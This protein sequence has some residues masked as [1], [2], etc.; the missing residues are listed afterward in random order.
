M[1]LSVILTTIGRPTLVNTL[2]SLAELRADDEVIVC[3]DGVVPQILQVMQGFRLPDSRPVIF[4]LPRAHDWGHTLRNRYSKLA[5]RDYILYMDDDDCYVPGAFDVIRSACSQHPDKLV[6]FGMQGKDGVI[7]R[8]AE[9][10]VGNV[11]TQNGAVPN[12]PA[13]WG[14][15]GTRYEGDFDFYNSCQ[16]EI[17]WKHDQVT[18]VIRPN[19]WDCPPAVKQYVTFTGR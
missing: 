10:R 4:H 3:C 17:A 18:T 8:S 5:S 2:N 7:P 15:W 19:E 11:S 13:R 1:R 16:F 12:I 14:T 9:L 6:I